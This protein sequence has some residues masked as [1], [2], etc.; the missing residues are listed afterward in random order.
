MRGAFP[1]SAILFALATYLI[2]QA[3]AA[4]PTVTGAVFYIAGGLVEVTAAILLSLGLITKFGFSLSLVPPAVFGLLMAIVQL[5]LQT[6][7][8][9]ADQLTQ[10]IEFAVAGLLIFVALY[11]QSH[12]FITVRP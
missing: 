2:A 1:I 6:A 4:G 8:G 7:V 10:G 9:T 5:I 12:G 11:L 3:V